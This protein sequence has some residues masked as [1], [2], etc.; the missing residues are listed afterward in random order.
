MARHVQLSKRRFLSIYF[1]FFSCTVVF[2]D[3]LFFFLLFIITSPG[4]RG[5]RTW[6]IGVFVISF[7][8]DILLGVRCIGTGV[9]HMSF[10][11]GL[12]DGLMFIYYK[13]TMHSHSDT[14][15]RLQSNK[16]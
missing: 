2:I 12:L 14:S 1:L 11:F 10:V 5:G 15:L 9:L 16:T 7:A 3:I 6:V 4:N 8:V 13:Y